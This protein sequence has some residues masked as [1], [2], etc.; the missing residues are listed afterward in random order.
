MHK[1]KVVVAIMLMMICLFISVSAENMEYRNPLINPKPIS[2]YVK[3]DK[4]IR[5]ILLLGIDKSDDAAAR[6]SDYHTDAILVI[7]VNFDEDKIDL[8]SLP[9][10]TLTYIPGIKGIYK[11]NAAINTGGGKTKE[12]FQRVCDAV[13]WVLGGIKI[14]HYCAV[15]MQAMA[16]IGDAIGGVDFEL[17]MSYTGTYGKYRKGLQ[18]LN[19]KGIM[20]YLR[21]RRN[22]TLNANDLGRTSRQRDLIM[23]IL[24]KMM[25]DRNSLAS[26]VT[27]VQDLEDGF[28]TNMSIGDMAAFLPLALRGDFDAT[29][30]HVIT[31]KYRTALNG[32]NFTFTDQDNRRDVIRSVY[33]V[34]VPELEYVSYAYTKWLMED[35]FAVV[36][37]LAVAQLMRERIN[38]YGEAVMS[39]E[40]KEA[41]SAF[42]LAYDQAAVAFDAAADSMSQTDAKRM[43]GAAKE[44]RKQGDA[45]FKLFDGIDKPVWATG[46]YWYA[47]RM[48][49][50]IDVNFR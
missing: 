20:D 6:G 9:R 7:A 40:Q 14:D 11:L 29:G 35:G 28:F 15:D 41:L 32:W 27:A 13:A 10:D 4:D 37:H 30:S 3:L 43:A 34:E 25:S 49:N 18:H 47:D 46:K 16:A 45:L 26:A 50:E 5:N 44:L 36:R 17:E 22:A 38:A 39:T 12:G 23:T 19:G 1:V 21:A 2:S 31:G 8:V 42:D 24:K 33:G 48:I